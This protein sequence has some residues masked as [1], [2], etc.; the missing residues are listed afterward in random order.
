[1]ITSD[2][3]PIEYDSFDFQGRNYIR[4]IGRNSKGKRVCI[5]DSCDV[6]FWAILNEKI[7]QKRL[8][9]IIKRI[10]EIQLDT[11][12][13]KTKV[14]SVEVHDK[15]FLEKPVKALKIFCTNY[16]DLH[17]IASE[18]NFPEIEF[19]RGY[20]LGFITHYILEKD[21]KPLCWYEIQGDIANGKFPGI[22]NLD[23]DLCIELQK[24]KPI[25]N[26]NFKPKSLSYDIET[27]D[28]KIGEGEILM[29]SLVS[30]NFKK[31]ITWKKSGNKEKDWGNIEYVKDEE[32]LLRAFIKHVKEISPDFL[33]GY[34]SDGFDLPYLRARAEKLK[35]PL[36]IG[37]DGSQPK[38]SRG[39]TGGIFTGKVLGIV[40]IDLLKF[41]QTA[42]S[43]Y[44]QSETMSLNEVSKEFL[45]EEK[46]NFKIKHSSL[47]ED[48]NWEDYYEY[49]LQDSV[50]TSKLFDKIWP[51]L[52]EFTK[53]MQEPIF[54]I[55]R[56]GMSA[57]VED[58][59]IHNLKKFNEIPEKRPIHDEILQRRQRERYEGAF[60]F[61][62][63]PGL[64]E[65]IAFFDFT[66][67]WPSIIVTYNLSRSTLLEK[68]IENST[69]IEVL[70]KKVYF[71]KKPGFFPQMLKEI[72][73]KRKK[74]KK[75]LS[76][77]PDAMKRARS[78][79]Y[80]LLANASYGYMGF[81]GARYY[82]P[83]ASGAA[84]AIGRIWSK[85]T[86]DEIN[87]AGYTTI[88]SDTD[89][90]SFLLNKRSKTEALS[91]LKELNK[92][93]PG[94]MELELEGFF[95]RGIWVTK[96]TGKIGAKK[97]YALID[98]NKKLKI[99]G[100]ETVRRDWCN[101]ARK[102]QNNVIKHV[103]EEGNEKKSLEYLK[104][105]INQIKKRGVNKEDLIIKTQL[106]KP[107]LEYKAISPHVIAARRMKE[108]NIPISQGNVIEYFIAESQGKKKLVRDGVKL[109]QE[110]GNYDIKYYLK[111]QLIPSVENIFQVFD[112]D[113]NEIAEGKKQTKLGDF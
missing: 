73:E 1:M 56:N 109:P 77:K 104:E 99:R 40:H 60:V 63:T 18:L 9:K 113:I 41:I 27:D 39:R 94:I 86:I 6:Y 107:L 74:Y 47:I 16:K 111:N 105:V 102:V 19:R 75:E 66:S 96:R 25:E 51:D 3:I 13:R 33:V 65:D 24:V 106:K 64:Y 7:N 68:K 31:V 76:E 57:N 14:E 11:K 44:M 55:S 43:P 12:G 90:I 48:H 82:C 110:E 88:Y 81:F 58:Y 2:F 10:K 34:F 98:E 61:E 87:N 30:D 67:F 54:D 28:I 15:N 4:I 93:L 35:V 92:R 70:G 62:P 80:K 91:F 85:K 53:I 46:K 101:L 23:V 22:E 20:D 49:N 32:E 72:I 45:G 37:L 36:E 83:E 89:S 21:I 79:A 59:I 38:F 50:L 103:L 97:K 112:I 69:E 26:E 17:E 78:N 42:Y 108:R 52:L 84:T 100:F 5:L 95:K 8:D 29:I 71:S